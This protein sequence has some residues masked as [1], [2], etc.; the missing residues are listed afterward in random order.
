MAKISKK[1]HSCSLLFKCKWI[2]IKP[3]TSIEI[4]R[5]SAYLARVSVVLMQRG[6]SYI[7]GKVSVIEKYT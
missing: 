3:N 1:S 2:L 6:T 4:T 7:N 5:C